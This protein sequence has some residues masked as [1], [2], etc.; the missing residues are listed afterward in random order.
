MCLIY[1]ASGSPRRRELV[2]QLNYTFE[3]LR[4]EV[5]EQWQEGELPQDY[6][7]RLARDKSLAGV[8]IAPIIN[9]FWAQIQSLFSQ[10]NFR[11]TAR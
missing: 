8:A 1:L 7:Q 3:V 2:Q 9:R 6:V 11:K 10:G 5:E 4:P